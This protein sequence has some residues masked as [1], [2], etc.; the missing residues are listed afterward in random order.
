MPLDTR[1]LILARPSCKTMSRKR[2][3]ALDLGL[4]VNGVVVADSYKDAFVILHMDVI[5]THDLYTTLTTSIIPEYTCA[6]TTILLENI[7]MYR[8]F[9]LHRIHKR[10]K[11]TFLT[12]CKPKPK[13]KC[14]LPSQK[15]WDVGKRLA[16]SKGRDRKT[17]AQQSAIH[18]LS[19]VLHDETH[20]TRF[21]SF[22][23]RNHD[24]ADALMM[25]FYMH[26]T[27]N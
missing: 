26:D 27:Q 23:A 17:K 10:I 6:N 8:N 16:S 22:Q 2:I 9:A 24:L 13:V 12:T 3:I 14:L 15:S 20:L 5:D 25:A 7:F 21:N 19:N 1:N 18:L 11:E 4:Q